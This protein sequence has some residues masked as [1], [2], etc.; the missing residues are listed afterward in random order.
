MEPLRGIGKRESEALTDRER[1]SA[2]RLMDLL[3]CP[4]CRGHPLALESGTMRC[5]VCARTYAVSRGLPILLPDGATATVERYQDEE[6]D[7]SPG[8]E[9]PSS[10]EGPVLS[11]ALQAGDAPPDW[12]QV[13]DHISETADL[14]A[15]IHRLPFRDAVFGTILSFQGLEHSPRPR[16]ATTEL[17][18]VLRPGGRLLIQAA[19]VQPLGTGHPHY[20]HATEYGARRWLS[21]FEVDSCAVPEAMNPALAVARIFTEVLKEVGRTQGQ[22]AADLLAKT[23]LAQWREI[24]ADPGSRSGFAWE[25]VKRLPAEVEKRFAL[26]LE[27][28]A[29]KAP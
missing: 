16:A 26:A 22:D 20:Y 7:G 17:H 9:L 24:W 3:A 12:V 1:K 18:R 14:V 27:L 15:D 4:E 19:F 23:T 8:V 13:D 10:V 2:A 29:T 5:P 6:P 11:L 28:E 25:M 21:A